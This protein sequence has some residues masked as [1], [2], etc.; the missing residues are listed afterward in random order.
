MH[1]PNDVRVRTGFTKI[2]LE[3]RNKSNPVKIVPLHWQG[4]KN[5]VICLYLLTRK[6][7]TAEPNTVSFHNM[8]QKMSHV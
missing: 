4:S 8:H 5:L 3:S 7:R 2:L 1:K 6:D